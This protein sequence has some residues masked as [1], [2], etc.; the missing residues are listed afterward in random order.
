MKA[1]RANPLIKKVIAATFPEY[2]GRL[3]R[4]VEYTGPRWWTV[5]W[6]EGSRDRVS[7]IDLGRGI[8]EFRAG[9]PFTNPDGVLAKVDQPDGSILVVH[10]IVAG[11]DRGLTIIVRPPIHDQLAM[12]ETARVTSG[13]L[14]AGS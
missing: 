14:G 3:I 4:V 9:S 11:Q 1:S 6:D 7:L 12:R 5:C 2:R 13:L 10:S 8:A